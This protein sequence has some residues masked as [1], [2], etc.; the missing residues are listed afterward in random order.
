[1]PTGD[2][3]PDT[4]DFTGKYNTQLAPQ[5][6]AAYQQWVNEQSQA[7]GRNVGADAYDYDLRGWWLANPGVSL[8]DGHLTDQFKKPNHPTFSD[9][10]QYS[11]VDGMQGGQ[12]GKADNG[13]WSFTP[14]ATNMFSTPELSDYFKRVEPGN[15]LNIPQN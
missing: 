7:T 3:E 12:W 4:L 8:G 14:G 6:E 2:N 9:Q 11:G 13:S 15:Q 10:S 5:G 1:M